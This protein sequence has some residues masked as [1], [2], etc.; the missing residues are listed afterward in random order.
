MQ[1]E[2]GFTLIELMIVVAVIAILAAIAI[3]SYQDYVA[4]SQSSVGLMDIR[5]GMTAFEELVQLGRGTSIT[6]PEDVG[7]NTSSSRCTSISVVGGSTGNITCTLRGNPAID[8]FALS[9]TRDASAVPRWTCTST[10]PQDKHK[11]GNCL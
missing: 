3:P 10:V 5:S 1:A 9:L 11:P 8:G 4:R 6:A 2:R 7:L